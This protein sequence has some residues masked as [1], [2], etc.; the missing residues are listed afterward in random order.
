M[1]TSYSV[2]ES[3]RLGGAILKF[4]E[5]HQKNRRLAPDQ[6]EGIGV[7]FF[8][9]LEIGGS[10]ENLLFPIQKSQT[11]LFHWRSDAMPFL[12]L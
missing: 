5:Y 2:P 3:K 7:G 10:F 6:D 11:P 4:L 12:S 8:G 1:P 9:F